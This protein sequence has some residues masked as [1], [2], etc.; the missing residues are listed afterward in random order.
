MG[1]EGGYL[2]LFIEYINIKTSNINVN[3]CIKSLYDIY[4]PPKS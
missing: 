1:I 4:Y 2:S 3:V